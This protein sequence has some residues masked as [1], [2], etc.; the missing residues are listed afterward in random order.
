MT[1]S[2][3]LP[4]LLERARRSG[5]AAAARRGPA[6]RRTSRVRLTEVEAYAGADDPGSHAFRGR[7]PRNEVMFGDAGVPLRVLHL[8]HAPLRNVVIGPD[9]VAGAVLLRGGRGDRRR[10]RALARQRGRPGSCRTLWASRSHNGGDL[11][12]RDPVPCELA[13]PLPGGVGDRAAGGTGA[14]ADT[15]WRFWLTGEP[16]VSTYRPAAPR[17]PRGSP[18]FVRAPA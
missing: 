8:R 4:A 10:R 1:G 15:P 3:D 9:G 12:R 7:T 11:T 17:R 18:P 14:A 16:S 5:R 2:A 13:D 6:A